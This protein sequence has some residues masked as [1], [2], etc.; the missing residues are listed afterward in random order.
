MKIREGFVSNS[1]STSFCIL[2]VD[3]TAE[4]K[5]IERYQNSNYYNKMDIG[6]LSL[7]EGLENL[8]YHE[9]Y[10]LGAHPS[11]MRPTETLFEFKERIVEEM[12]EKCDIDIDVDDL[13]W[14]EDAGNDNY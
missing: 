14:L 7:R 2:G 5:L 9:M 12:K 11:E 1:S 13:K 10:Y 6:C 3:V 4:R 8:G